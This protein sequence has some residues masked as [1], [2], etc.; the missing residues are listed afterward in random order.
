MVGM[1]LLQEQGFHFKSRIEGTRGILRDEPHEKFQ[2]FRRRAQ[3]HRHQPRFQS[4]QRS[5]KRRRGRRHGRRP[6]HARRRHGRSPRPGLGRPAHPHRQRRD[7]LRRRHVLRPA[8]RTGGR[9][10]HALHGQPLPRRVPRLVG[11]FH[12]PAAPHGHEPSRHGA[13]PGRAPRESG[14]RASRSGAS[15]PRTAGVHAPGDESV[16]EHDVRGREHDDGS[17]SQ[18]A[19][20]DAAW[21]AQHGRGG[22]C[23]C[24]GVG[25]STTAQEHRSRYQPRA[26]RGFE[27]PLSTASQTP[28]SCSG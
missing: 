3:R 10:L 11:P 1:R 27:G 6:L 16:H 4:R 22:G 18:H 13:P 5:A 28:C 7:P 20:R 15:S 14:R 25:C 12:A 24:C 21:H 8:R 26:H 2:R 19:V 23:R 17:A 9:K